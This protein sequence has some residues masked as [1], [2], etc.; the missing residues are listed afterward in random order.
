MK[1]V[2]NFCG[3]ASW[4]FSARRELQNSIFLTGAMHADRIGTSIRKREITPCRLP[5]RI[6]IHHAA[7]SRGASLSSNWMACRNLRSQPRKF[8]VRT[9]LPVRPGSGRRSTG[10]ARTDLARLR[11]RVCAPRRSERHRRFTMSPR[12]SPNRRHTS[13]SRICRALPPEATATGAATDVWMEEYAF[14]SRCALLP[15]RGAKSM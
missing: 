4:L 8:R 7:S 9:R 5:Q 11:I 2:S 3:V 1:W 13:L 14:A 10:F 6:R 12:N 15:R